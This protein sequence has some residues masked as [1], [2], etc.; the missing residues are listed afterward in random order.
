MKSARVTPLSEGP[1]VNPNALLRLRANWHGD[2]NSIA[3]GSGHT[4]SASRIYG[5]RG[6]G[7][8]PLEGHFGLAFKTLNIMMEA[9]PITLVS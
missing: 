4:K 5:A 1:A 7:G 3:S 8:A 2:I 6:H 9:V